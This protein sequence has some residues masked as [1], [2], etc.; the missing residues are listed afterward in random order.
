MMIAKATIALSLVIAGVIVA[1]C[2]VLFLGTMT[3]RVCSIEMTEAKTFDDHSYFSSSYDEARRKFLYAAR[4][5]GGRV[6]SIEHPEIGPDG[7]ALYIDVVYFGAERSTKALVISSGTH[8]VEGFAGSGVQTGLMKS[9]F[10][11][12]LPSDLSLLMIH[13]LNPYGMAYLR[14]FNEDNVDLNRNFRDHSQP[15]PRNLSYEALADAITPS[16]MSFWREVRSWSQLLL[17]RITE[18]KAQSRAAVS[19]GQYTHPTGLFYGG[20][21]DTWS[22]KA[23][24]SIVQRYLRTKKQVVIVDVHTGLGEYAGAEV[25]LNTPADSP[26][27]QRAVHIWG[28][29]LVKTTVTGKSVSVHLD[30]TL[31]LA[32]TEM[33]PSVEV[34]AVS[35]EFGTLPP[36]AV[37]KALRAENWLY[38]HATT[39]HPKASEIKACLLR[40]FYPDD[41]EWRKSVF[42]KGKDIVERAVWSLSVGQDVES[43][44]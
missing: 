33:L 14:R 43:A 4:D 11:S 39:E 12:S 1:V 13:G 31:K 8:G 37:F 3:S 20:R 34:T 41:E 24:R 7:Q 44:S 19:E 6:E 2:I 22:S 16:S 42:I 15:I 18:G 23:L 35:L 29:S 38:H 27:F 28:E 30:A 32:F 40:A 26:E 17:F 9:G 36:M 25:I 21:K 10:I 5:L